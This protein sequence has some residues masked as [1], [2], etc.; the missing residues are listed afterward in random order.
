MS[1]PPRVASSFAG[2]GTPAGTTRAALVGRM[3][4]EWGFA[5]E[6]EAEGRNDQGFPVTRFAWI[7]GSDRA[8]APGA[9]P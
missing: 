5:V 9:V 2:T 4:G 1:S 6:G 3:L 7:D 8:P